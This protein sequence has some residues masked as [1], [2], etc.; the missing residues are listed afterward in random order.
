MKKFNTKI[1]CTYLY[2]I[3]KYGYPPPAEDTLKYIEE[4][5]SLG[6]SNIEL[7]GIREE[8]IKKVYDLRYKIRTSLD[9]NG[10]TLPYFCVVLPGLSSSEQKEREKN[11]GIFKLGCETAAICG[12]KGVLDN[13]PIPPY[14]FPKD[15]PVVRHYE[16][17][18]LQSASLPDN[19]E[20][21]EYYEMLVSTFRNL[22][23]IASNYDL[24]YQLHPAS[25]V[26]I[27]TADS[28]LHFYNSV[29]RE[30]LRFNFDTANL[31]A[32][33]ENLPLSLYK[34]KGHIDYIHFSDNSGNKVEH[35]EAGKGKINWNIFFAALKAINYEGYIGLDI[36]GDESG[37]KNLDDA[38]IN[39]AQFLENNWFSK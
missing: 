32:I 39:S 27:N 6:F 4:M 38:Y 15:I 5:T 22:C 11:I 12:A 7:E 13:S 18:S 19:F 3:T 26:L 14:I 1:V 31:F 10:L 23:D 37:V 35:L 16:E 2:S 24:N 29:G 20:W 8:H 30:N 28:F 25:G 21:K 9:D 36:G 33:K 34:L 17:E